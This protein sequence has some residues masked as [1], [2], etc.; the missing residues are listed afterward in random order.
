M[1]IVHRSLVQLSVAQ[2]VLMEVP[3]LLLVDVPVFLNG[4]D[5]LVQLVRQ[6]CVSIPPSHP[7]ALV[8]SAIDSR[9]LYIDTCMCENH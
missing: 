4:L 5:P 9:T 8:E 6:I 1:K 2:A 7:I 3:A